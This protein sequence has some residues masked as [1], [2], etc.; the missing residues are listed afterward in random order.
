MLPRPSLRSL[1]RQ[2][3]SKLDAAYWGCCVTLWLMWRILGIVTVVTRTKVSCPFVLPMG[4]RS[5][6]ILGS[7]CE[8]NVNKVKPS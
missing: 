3:Y 6:V 7:G 8:R 1:G 5:G 2:G 4:C